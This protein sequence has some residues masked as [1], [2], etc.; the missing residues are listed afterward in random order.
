VDRGYVVKE[1]KAFKPT[2]LGVVVT[3]KIFKDHFPKIVNVKFT[4][5]MES[6]LDEIEQGNLS[7]GKM[8]SDFYYDLDTTL[9]KAKVDLKDTKFRLS[10][11]VTDEIC[12][13][14][15]RKMVKMTG[16]F[17]PFLAC[18]GY[19]ECKNSKPLKLK[20]NALCPKCG[21]NVIEK[22]VRNKASSVFYGC[23][24][25]PACDFAT[26]NTPTGENCPKCGSSLFADRRGNII[27]ENESCDYKARAPRKGKSDAT[28]KSQADTEAGTEE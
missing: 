3:L 5:S 7:M 24:R 17:G 11:D 9:K 13:K 12:E 19:P 8:L 6:D 27:C 25:W 16:R 28:A 20:T 18:E 10:E 4:A 26:W 1:N 22:R 14:C 2:E 23:E 15:G 21:A